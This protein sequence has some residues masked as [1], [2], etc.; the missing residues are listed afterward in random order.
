LRCCQKYV[1]SPNIC[2]R[3]QIPQ[4]RCQH[5]KFESGLH[6]I[7]EVSVTGEDDTHQIRVNPNAKSDCHNRKIWCLLFAQHG[8]RSGCTRYG[9]SPYTIHGIHIIALEPSILYPNVSRLTPLTPGNNVFS[10]AGPREVKAGTCPCLTAAVASRRAPK[11][12]AILGA[13]TR[14]L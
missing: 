1:P 2:V 3:R 5:Q 8:W 9:F 4:I 14:P 13:G 10:G 6:Q 7:F 11:L 12:S